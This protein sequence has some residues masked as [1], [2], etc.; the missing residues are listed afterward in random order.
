MTV[1]FLKSL[2]IEYDEL[3]VLLAGDCGL[4]ESLCVHHAILLEHLDQVLGSEKPLTLTMAIASHVGS[5]TRSVRHRITNPSVDVRTCLV[6]SVSQLL[7]GELIF[8]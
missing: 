8:G 3:L 1:F 2:S 4:H 6:F 5:R 7:K